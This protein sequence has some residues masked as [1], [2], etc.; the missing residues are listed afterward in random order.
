[1]TPTLLVGLALTLGSHSSITPK[2]ATD[3]L[4]R[5]MPQGV[6]A[7]AVL[8]D[9][10]GFI[11]RIE[12]SEA[13]KRLR[14][15]KL[16]NAAVEAEV[17][18]RWTEFDKVMQSKIGVGVDVLRRDV[19]G[20]SVAL[21]YCPK[22]SEGRNETGLFLVRARSAERLDELLQSLFRL[23]GAEP[24]RR[25][26]KG[27]EYW[28]SKEGERKQFLLTLGP[29]GLLTDD[30]EAVRRVIQ[31]A[32]GDPSWATDP[33]FTLMR[34][35]TPTGALV[36]V[37]VIARNLDP[38]LKD[39]PGP[40]PAEARIQET[41]ESLWRSV[42]W[43]SWTLQ[44]ESELSM[45]L[46]AS[47]DPAKLPKSMTQ[48]AAASTNPIPTQGLANAVGSLA[49][50]VDL[51]WVAELLGQVAVE[52]DPK[53]AAEG[54]RFVRSLFMGVDPMK[55]LVPHVGPRFGLSIL[56]NGDKL[57]GAVAAVELRNVK[58]PGSLVE[59]DELVEQALRFAAL[60]LAFEAGK[61]TGDEWKLRM[62]AVDGARVHVAT[63]GKSLPE[64]FEP[65]FT[66]HNGWVLF[67]TSPDA[68]KRAMTS[69]TRDSA[70]GEFGRLDLKAANKSLLP[71]LN[72][73]KLPKPERYDLMQSVADAVPQVLLKS[74]TE[75]NVRH[76]TME[77]PAPK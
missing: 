32:K 44:L 70:P 33:V 47:I 59:P 8:E 10:D 63:G 75:G 3:D 45:G 65:C 56:E 69:K 40:T 26:H 34:K 17:F 22:G 50:N 29:I 54:G 48:V 9:L 77:A 38:A 37:Y 55:D 68:V 51:A 31:T 36:S 71:V 16:L 46:H 41:A 67:A 30:E 25:S 2:Q 60:V 57:P 62:E 19:F 49:A 1:M 53:G 15:A 4:F 39:K 43:A 42:D 12:Q 7:V 23:H 58:S 14:K 21:G 35:S 18:R 5:A 66:V 73:A 11:S 20:L 6:A 76:W 27:V 61:N 28:T 64:G 74:R 52:S 24:P 13:V 72:A